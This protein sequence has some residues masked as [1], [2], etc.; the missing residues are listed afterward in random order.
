MDFNVQKMAAVIHVLRNGE[1]HAVAEITGVLDT[2]AMAQLLIDRFK[3]KGH[4]I[5]VYPDASGNARKSQNASESDLA[6]LRKHFSV[7]VNP[8]NPLVKDRVLATNAMFHAGGRR[9]YRV[10][11]DACPHLTEAFEQQCYDKNGEPDKS[12]GLD[13]VIDAATYYIAYSFPVVRPVA[14]VTQLRM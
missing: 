2:P 12:T 10:N 5:I 14:V 13:H 9:R 3:S 4:P 6:I 8:A 1:P 7:F 11:V